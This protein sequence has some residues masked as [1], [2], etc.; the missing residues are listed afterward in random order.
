MFWSKC[1]KRYLHGH[2]HPTGEI[3]GR[4]L[5][6]RASQYQLTALSFRERPHASVAAVNGALAASAIPPTYRVGQVVPPA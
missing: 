5:I 6:Y 2:A 1:G 4:L 3:G